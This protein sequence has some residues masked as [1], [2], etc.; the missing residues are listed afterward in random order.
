MYQNEATPR[1]HVR[2]CVPHGRKRCCRLLHNAFL[3][4]KMI[5]GGDQALC[6]V[7]RFIQLLEKIATYA[8]NFMLGKILTLFTVI[9][10]A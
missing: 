2:K 6:A 5:D 10:P 4:S 9:S 1:A 3:M 8:H 7:N